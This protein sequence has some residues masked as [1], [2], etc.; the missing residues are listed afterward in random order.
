MGIRGV[1]AIVVMVTGAVMFMIYSIVLHHNLTGARNKWLT[2][3][4]ILLLLS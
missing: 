3:I 4:L 1:L 2:G